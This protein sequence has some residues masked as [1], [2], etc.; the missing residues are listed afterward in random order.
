MIQIR[1][2]CNSYLLDKA[3]SRATKEAPATTGA[4]PNTA[5]SSWPN[6][7]AME[8][9]CLM[10]KPPRSCHLFR[11]YRH[12]SA[13]HS[14]FRRFSVSNFAGAQEGSTRAENPRGSRMARGWGWWTGPTPS[15][16]NNPCQKYIWNQN[17]RG[18]GNIFVFR[19]VAAVGP[20]FEAARGDEIA[21][22]KR[23][24]GYWSHQVETMPQPEVETK[25]P[26]PRL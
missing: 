23:R 22:G 8:K 19:F 17:S 7:A 26:L 24:K 18:A 11:C 5:R 14:R 9:R 6:R 2:V 12:F 10:A 3:R 16:L 13:R 21:W 4:K 20:P 25:P 15:S 1:K